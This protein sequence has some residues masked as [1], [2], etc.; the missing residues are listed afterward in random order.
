MDVAAAAKMTIKNTK[1]KSRNVYSMFVQIPKLYMSSGSGKK[2]RKIEIGTTMQMQ[3][4]K[5][6]IAP[7]SYFPVS[8]LSSM[9]FLAISLSPLVNWNA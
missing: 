5:K 3:P 1:K 7:R 9:I 8:A 4:I 2:T 6:S